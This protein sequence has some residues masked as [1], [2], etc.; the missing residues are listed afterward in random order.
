MINYTVTA[1]PDLFFTDF[2]YEILNHR[3]KKEY[4]IADS[5]SKNDEYQYLDVL[6]EVERFIKLFDNTRLIDPD[7]LNQL[8]RDIL[9]NCIVESEYLASIRTT[10]LTLSKERKY[11]TMCIVF[12]RLRNKFI[13]ANIIDLNK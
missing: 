4:L 12:N 11:E 5:L 2:E 3:L 7:T 10:P 8:Q 1:T 9:G 6:E 13:S